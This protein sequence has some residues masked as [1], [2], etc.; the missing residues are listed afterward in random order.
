MEYTFATKRFLLP[1]ELDNPNI[2]SEENVVGF[3]ARGL[4]DKVVPII[5]CHLQSEP[6]NHLR[7]AIRDYAIQHK[8][9]PLRY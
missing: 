7:L 2:S 9:N 1:E 4:F 6:T 5:T 8:L 3:H